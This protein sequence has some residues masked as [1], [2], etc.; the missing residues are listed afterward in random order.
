M[1]WYAEPLLP[2]DVERAINVLGANAARVAVLGYIVEHPHST[3]REIAD[4]TELALG[5]VKNHVATLV[6]LGALEADPAPSVPYAL[7]RGMRT[8]YLAQR[9]QLAEQYQRLGR[10]LKLDDEGEEPSV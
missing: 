10:L 5:T 6:A 1:P 7:R 8:R 9:Q 3:V 4:G 2:P